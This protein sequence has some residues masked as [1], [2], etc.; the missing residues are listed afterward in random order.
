MNYVDFLHYKE[1]P[2]RFKLK[3]GKEVYGVIWEEKHDDEVEYLFASSSAHNNY[4]ATE[5]SQISSIIYKLSLED[6]IYAEPLGI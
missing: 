6:V 4:K 5:N 3:S 1:Q 2:C